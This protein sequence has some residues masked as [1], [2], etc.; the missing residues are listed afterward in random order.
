MKNKI[1][2][3]FLIISLIGFGKEVVELINEGVV[4]LKMGDY[5]KAIEIFEDTKRTASQNPDIYYYLGE[6]YFRIGDTQKAVS[7]LQKAIDINPQKQS[8]HYTLA[9]VYLSQNKN[10]EAMESLD[11]VLKISSLSLYGKEAERLK[12]ELEKR[13]VE[14]EVVKKWEKI[15]IEEKSKKEET[16]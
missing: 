10:K 11:R 13:N 3:L 5:K 2:F 8:Y 12:K 15:E 9:L 14:T 4:Y 1:F 6:A 7:N 16:I